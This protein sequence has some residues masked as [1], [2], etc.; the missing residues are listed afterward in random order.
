MNTDNLKRC[1]VNRRQFLGRSAQQAAGVAAGVVGLTATTKASSSPNEK[2]G[3]GVI[4]VRNQGKLLA[5]ELTKLGDVEVRSLCDI[6]ETQ[7]APAAQAVMEQGGKAP[8][9]ER[10]FRRLL[11]DPSIDAVVIATP[12]HWHG[13]MTNLACLH[14]ISWPKG[15]RCLT[16]RLE[17]LA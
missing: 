12:D 3:V 7:F 16:R 13:S 2:L 10:D 17:H 4:G 9:T 1:E 6:D 5:A 8:S 11:D 14:R 15:S